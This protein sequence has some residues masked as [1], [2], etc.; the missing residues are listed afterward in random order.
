MARRITL[1][2]LTPR[3][4]SL[5]VAALEVQRDAAF[6]LVKEHPR[7][8]SRGCKQAIRELSEIEALLYQITGDQT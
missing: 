7:S 2:P 4:L 3:Q 6:D 5:I 8:R 1:K